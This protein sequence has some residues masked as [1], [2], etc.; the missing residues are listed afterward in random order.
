[1]TFVNT[2]YYK[3]KI[4]SSKF[5][6]NLSP[7]YT[8]SWISSILICFQLILPWKSDENRYPSINYTKHTSFVQL[9]CFT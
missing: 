5:R 4:R 8:K 3:N 1:M 2:F 7:P 9:T 6:T